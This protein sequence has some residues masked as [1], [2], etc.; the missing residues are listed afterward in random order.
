MNEHP[1]HLDRETA[2]QLL[3]GACATRAEGLD[4]T[5]DRLARLL[6]AAGGPPRPAEFSREEDAMAA[7]RA[8]SLT[9]RRRG[10]WR[11]LLTFKVLAV[12]ATITVGGLAF[13]STT[14]ILPAPFKQDTGSPSPPAISATTANRPASSPAEPQP[15]VSASPPAPSVRGHCH[16][17][18]SKDAEGRRRVVDTPALA[19]L[20]TAAGGKEHVEA[21]CVALTGNEKAEK[22]HQARPTREPNPPRASRR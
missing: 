13:A 2:E 8:A 11:K 22:P 20:V 14:G 9:S 17:Y 10:L 1:R 6:A 12:T 15:S 18:L 5:T 16:S 7:F 19:E 3:D 21:Y 4:D